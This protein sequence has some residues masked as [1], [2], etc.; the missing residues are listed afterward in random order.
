MLKK[1]L[2]YL[3][4]LSPRQRAAHGGA[5]IGAVLALA[6]TIIAP[7]EGLSTRPYFDSAHVKTI[8]YGATAADHVD[9]SKTYTPADCKKM[10]TD[11]LPKYDAQLAHCLT[12]A[13]YKALPLHRHAALISTVYNIG[14]GAFCKS[15]MARDL[16][17]GRVS[18]ACNDLMAYDHAGG[19][20]LLGLKRRRA[21]EKQ[22]C[23]M[24]D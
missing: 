17:A 9:F 14:G 19:R 7:L 16:N 15:S 22:L 4:S 24:G 3:R 1:L 5:G 6:A 20:E 11:D 21:A 13:V 23:L 8:C 12:P 18:Q 10:L 2:A